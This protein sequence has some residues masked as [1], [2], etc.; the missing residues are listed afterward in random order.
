MTLVCEVCNVEFERAGSRGP[1]PRRCSQACRAKQQRQKPERRAY[2]KRWHAAARA[3]GKRAAYEY[4][5]N[6]RP[7]VKSRN[8]ER[9]RVKWHTDPE[10]RAR[11]LARWANPFA[12]LQI[13]APYTGHRWL[14]MARNIVARDVDR[15]APWAEDYFDDM[16]EA[17][18]ALL[19]GRDMQEAVKAYRSKEFAA[20]NL[21]LHLGDWGD[22]EDQQ[23]RWFEGVMP[24]A[25][26]AED[27]A[28][29]REA[30]VY[31]L[32]TRYHHGSN[33]HPIHNRQ[34]QPSRRRMKDAG[35]RKAA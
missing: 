31:Y 34:Q 25:D 6:R 19:E 8:A 5:Y 9:M 22:D 14:E 23:N 21:T 11:Q 32:K 2:E 33:G 15:T 3:A 7:E 29:A 12:G 35:W 27:E 24:K 17:V 1:I 30:A 16:G 20:R 4:A 26:S 10:Y 13:P 28:I 18:L